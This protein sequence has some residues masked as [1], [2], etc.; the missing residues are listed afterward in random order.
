MGL[1]NPGRDYAQT[2]HNLGFMLLDAIAAQYKASS[3]RSDCRGQKADVTIGD[4]SLLL[5]K[6]DTFMNLSGEAVGALLRFY[7][8]PVHDTLVIHDDI[9]L[10]FASQRIKQGGGSGGHNGLKSLDA[11][12]T[13][14]YWRLRLG[15]GRPPVPLD[16]AA[17]VLQNF[18]IDEASALTPW[19]ERLTAAMPYLVTG[20]HALF[21]RKVTAA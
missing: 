8:I 4:T 5:F 11:H 18:S 17:Y 2:R 20:A 14:L 16:T 13:P 10:A 7:K 3:W 15:V 6:P 19:L 12:C 21:L 9:D 1:G